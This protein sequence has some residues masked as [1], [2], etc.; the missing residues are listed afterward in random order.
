VREHWRE[1]HYWLWFWQRRVPF[2]VKATVIGV[3]VCALLTAGLGAAGGL[4]SSSG[5]GNQELALQT[6]VEK[7]VTVREK[8]RIVRKLV[9]VAVKRAE[10]RRRLETV[11]TQLEY[12]TRVVSL[13]AN[14]P[15]RLVPVTRARLVTVDGKPQTVTRTRLN[16]VTRTQTAAVTRTVTN[17][18][19][20]T[21]PPETVTR[22][23]TNTL[24]R[25]E[26]RVE[27]TTRVE[28]QTLTQTRAET[29]T[30]PPQTVTVLETV[31]VTVPKPK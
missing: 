26:N 16:P 21:Q 12:V 6:T 9:P 11:L 22:E 13:A 20:I 1:I 23:Q 2:A 4:S 29:V 24:T 15:A 17:S 8:G 7:L 3:I 25:T 10:P 31:T 14:A 18:Q 19:N 28:T 30:L 27:T 5:G